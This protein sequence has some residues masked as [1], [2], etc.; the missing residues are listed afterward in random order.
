MKTTIAVII[1]RLIIIVAA[2]LRVSIYHSPFKKVKLAWNCRYQAVR[3]RTLPREV[4]P[5]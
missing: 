4:D 5:G 1:V 2:R 3:L